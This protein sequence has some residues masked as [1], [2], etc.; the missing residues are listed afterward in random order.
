MISPNNFYSHDHELIKL[1]QSKESYKVDVDDPV[2]EVSQQF[3]SLFVDMMLQ[4]M[5]KAT[6]K[7]DL[8][9]SHAMQ[10]YEQLFDQEI[11]K[12]LSK[13][14]VFGIAEAIERQILQINHL[15]SLYESIN[16]NVREYN[17]RNDYPLELA[18][19]SARRY[20]GRFT[21]CSKLA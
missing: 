3:E 10:T 19:R 6:Q 8:L 21:H 5:R 12:N 7:S 1:Q 18:D 2:K 4:S 13:S 14:S 15:K 11:A 9:D 16:G 20:E 17:R